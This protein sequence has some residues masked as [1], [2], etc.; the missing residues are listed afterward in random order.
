MKFILTLSLFLNE[1]YF[2]NYIR[3]KRIIVTN[4]SVRSRVLYIEKGKGEVRSERK[5]QNRKKQTNEQTKKIYIYIRSELKRKKKEK[6]EEEEI[7]DTCTCAR[8]CN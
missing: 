7:E 4:F 2:I 3:E 6:R 8:C 1:T 5:K